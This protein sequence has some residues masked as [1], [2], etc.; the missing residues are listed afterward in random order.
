MNKLLLTS[1]LLAILIGQTFGQGLT[2]TIRGTVIDSDSKL[3]LIGVNVIIV[4][5]NSTIGTVTDIDGKFRLQDVPTGRVSL[6]F[7]YLGYETKILRNLVV[8]SGKEVV[9]EVGMQQAIKSTNRVTVKGKKKKQ[10]EV[11]NDMSLIGSQSISPEE[12]SRYAGGFNDPSRITANFAGVSTTGDGGNDII[13]RGNSPKYIQWRLEG[14]QITN[15][16][17]F[18]D[19]SSVGGATSVLNNNVMARSDFYTGAFT[20]EFGDVLSGIYDVSLR[21]GNNEKF[22]AVFGFGLLGTDITL[23][24]P[25]KKGYAGSYIVNYRY[26]TAGL[27]SDMGLID[28][29]G[30]PKFQDASFK[31]DLPTKKMGRFSVFGLGGMSN[32]GFEDVKPALWQTPGNNSMKGEISEDFEKDAHLA[33]IGLNHTLSLNKKSF[34]KTSLTYSNEGIKDNILETKAIKLY[35]N[36]GEY[37]R[38]SIVSK[39]DNYKSR[40]TKSTYRGA[41]T[42]SNKINRK[43]KIIIG[44]KYALFD[45]D[46]KQSQYLD[47]PTDRFTLVDFD[48]NLSTIRNFVSWK[49][50]MNNKF[51]MVYG[52]HNMNVLLNSKSTIEQRFA[53]KWKVNPRNS[54][55]FGFGDHSTMESIHN[56]FTKVESPNG[57][58]SEPNKDLGLLKA[59][60][61]VLGYE[62]TL[63]KYL[64][65]KV[66]AY[67]QDLYNLPVENNDTSYYATINEGLEFRYVDLVNEGTGKNYG[68]EVTLDKGFN[69]NYY[70]LINASIYNSKYT[71]LDGIERNTQYNGN[72]LVNVLV[73]KEFERLGKK[74]NKTLGLNGKFFYGGGKKVIPLLRNPKGE[75]AV[76]PANNKF[77][78]YEKAYEDKIENIYSA[79]ISAS[80]KWN[81]PKATHELFLNI[82][83]V[84]NNKG[85]LSE[86]Y[87]ESEPNSVGHVKQFGIFPNLMYR[88]YF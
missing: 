1:F 62:K 84:T 16:N 21:K 70:Y 64:N 77:Y 38:D 80:L 43:H 10:N 83:N 45:Y 56:Y 66:E 17:H 11:Q 76:D 12:T 46:N 25:L 32:L 58:V 48:D 39:N 53:I 42:Y 82:D 31:L 41:V 88:V 67:Y 78:D 71:A 85:K 20:A 8:N 35:D 7:S 59:R 34:I 6:K 30:I 68:L 23:E 86:Y 4:D 51:T 60:H 65:L 49:Y 81:K 50:R 24:G 72:Y 47:D 15:P 33:N 5:S 54:L 29:N 57:S 14:V 28:I 27:I 55:S 19:Q 13:V 36:N 9:L 18:A 40:I 26:S 69:K 37:L 61:Y 79:T 44:T 87:D 73:G 3:Q 52:I 74:Q 2:Q 22:E 75:L 63:S